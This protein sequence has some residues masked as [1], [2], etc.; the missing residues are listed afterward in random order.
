MVAVMLHAVL[1]FPGICRM[2]KV[3]LHLLPS[4]GNKLLQEQLQQIKQ[5][6]E[7]SNS[8]PFWKS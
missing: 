6:V 8:H 1:F 5:V 3:L 7:A 2:W 4:Q